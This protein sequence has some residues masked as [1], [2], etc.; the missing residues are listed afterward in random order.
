[1]G[2]IMSMR[3]FVPVV[4]ANNVDSRSATSGLSLHCLSVTSL[5]VFRLK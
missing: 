2:T 3:K 5:G 1:M 4:K